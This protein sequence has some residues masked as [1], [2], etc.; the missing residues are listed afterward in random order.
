MLPELQREGRGWGG[1]GEALGGPARLGEAAESARRARRELRAR[2]RVPPLPWGVNP[3]PPT[4]GGRNG[5]QI[6]PKKEHAAKTFP[7]RTRSLPGLFLRRRLPRKTSAVPG[8]AGPG[9]PG[10]LQR[11]LPSGVPQA[12]GSP[13]PK[14]SPAADIETRR[15]IPFPLSAA[16]PAR[17][18]A[19]GDPSR[20]GAGR[21]GAQGPPGSAPLPAPLGPPPPGHWA[22]LL[23]CKIT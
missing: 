10:L 20:G 16:R 17:C 4:S 1:D 19:P 12:P 6:F 11:P 7:L 14:G 13:C 15:G 18:G 8:R 2:P 9:H 22:F 23:R 21:A 3:S 5:L